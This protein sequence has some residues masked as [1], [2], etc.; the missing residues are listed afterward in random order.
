MTDRAFRAILR[1]TP[2]TT[3]Q[4]PR[5]PARPELCDIPPGQ[6]LPYTEIGMSDWRERKRGK[7]PLHR[8]E[9]LDR[10][11]RFRLFESIYTPGSVGATFLQKEC[12]QVYAGLARQRD[13]L[14]GN[15][16]AA[17]RALFSLLDEHCHLNV[18]CG[19]ASVPLVAMLDHLL[20]ATDA[21][22]VPE[23]MLAP[24]LLAACKIYLGTVGVAIQTEDPER[25]GYGRRTSVRNRNTY[26]S[27]HM[28]IFPR[29]WERTPK[30][31]F[32]IDY[33]LKYYVEGRRIAVVDYELFSVR[34]HGP[35]FSSR[36]FAGLSRAAQQGR[37]TDWMEAHAPDLEERDVRKLDAL[38]E[39]G[40][41]LWIVTCGDVVRDPFGMALM[42]VDSVV[43][44]D[45]ILAEG[46][47]TS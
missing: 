22:S 8:L 9:Q 4:A 31:D 3:Q 28:E 35:L 38:L 40:R 15:G 16:P 34:H 13:V 30:G 47:H 43:G 1:E 42:M 12:P 21:D 19:R 5:P 45:P 11:D 18:H 33:T 23:Q 41:D 6:H 14:R 32:F 27:R 24:F 39:A 26:L 46:S 20:P 7:S 2:S 37:G 25:G 36:V 29:K 10:Q 44:Q 17:V